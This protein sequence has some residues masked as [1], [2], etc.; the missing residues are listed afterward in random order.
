MEKLERFRLMPIYKDRKLIYLAVPKTGS[1]SVVT[2]LTTQNCLWHT[3]IIQIWDRKKKRTLKR[4]S[5]HATAQEIKDNFPNEWENFKKISCVRN[6]YSRMWSAF[7]SLKRCPQTKH[8]VFGKMGK[9]SFSDVVHKLGALGIQGYEDAIHN[10]PC[11][12][13]FFIHFLPMS[14]FLTVDEEIVKLDKL[15]RFENF[16]E[17]KNDLGIVCHR[18]Q[19]HPKKSYQEGYDNLTKTIVRS[20]YERD[21][22]HFKYSF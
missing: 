2:T 20:L 4:R 5:G 18:N 15:Y 12:E 3:D 17:M 16:D 11:K 19:T 13:D 10:H 22:D 14:D 21:L 9:C 8:P 1:T 6:P 7:W